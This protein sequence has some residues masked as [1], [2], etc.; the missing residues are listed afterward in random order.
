MISREQ[1]QLLNIE[2]IKSHPPELKE[3]IK[4]TNQLN[5]TIKKHERANS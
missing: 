4:L 3:L 2:I 5:K 1:N